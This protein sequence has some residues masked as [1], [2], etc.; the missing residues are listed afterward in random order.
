[1]LTGV[2]AIF[3]ASRGLTRFLGL[4]RTAGWMRSGWGCGV[5]RTGEYGGP[6]AA[7]QDDGEKQA[8]LWVAVGK[9]ADASLYWWPLQQYQL[10]VIDGYGYGW[11][12]C[13]SG[14]LHQQGCR[15]CAAGARV[16]PRGGACGGAGGGGGDE[17]VAAV[18]RVSGRDPREYVGVQGALQLWVVGA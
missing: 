5:R 13:C 3:G 8:R 16:P 11:Q 1:M 6:S 7:P 4:A 10:E 17:V 15:V 2:F 14:R 9:R 18:L 12:D